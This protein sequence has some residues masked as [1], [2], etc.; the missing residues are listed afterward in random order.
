MK[1]RPVY[2]DD[3][4]KDGNATGKIVFKLKMKNIDERRDTGR[5]HEIVVLDAKRVEINNPPQVGNGSVIRCAGFANPYYMA[6]SKEVGVSLAWQ[7][8]QIIDL[9]TYGS[10]D[11]FGE[12]EGYSSSSTESEVF[13][14]APF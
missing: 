12:E 1:A 9:I 11:D 3:T 10:G 13:E 2:T 8:M 5:P 4:D 14:E 6:S 7:K